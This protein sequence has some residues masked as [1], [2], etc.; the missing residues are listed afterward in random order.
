MNTLCID[1]GTTNIK[2]GFYQKNI[3][4]NFQSIPIKSH[5]TQDNH[6]IQKP[7]EIVNIINKSIRDL[8]SQ[9]LNI[10]MISFSVPMHTLIHHDEMILWS[11]LRANDW[12]IQFK[13]KEPKLAERFYQRT[14]TPIHPMSPFA[15]IGYLKQIKNQMFDFYY[16]LKE[17]LMHY[18]TEEF[19]IDYSTASATGLLNLNNLS[20][21][22]E[23]LNYLEIEE[24]QL[25]NLVDTDYMGSIL[26]QRSIELGLGEDVK[27]H[28]GATDGCLASLA[29]LENEG[30]NQVMTIG[31][32]G[33]A[34]KIVNQPMVSTETEDIQNFCYYIRQNQW[35]IGG[36][37]NNGGNI[38]DWLA[39][40]LFEDTTQFYGQL[41]TALKEIAPGSEGLKIYPYLYGERAPLWDANAQAS[42]NG[43]RALHSKQHFMKATVEG[44][45]F[46]L[47][48]ISTS[49]NFDGSISLNGGFFQIDGI[50]QLA[51]NILQQPVSYTKAS[52]PMD[53]L[54]CLINKKDV[55]K[56]EHLMVYPE[57]HEANLY[58]TAYIDWVK[59]LIRN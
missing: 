9:N 47:R 14:G 6:M 52:E 19:V 43:L 28:I 42:I 33:A 50:V 36:P 35:V 59:N 49:L 56:E 17:Y 8:I 13:E 11:D 30:A 26:Q 54:M 4:T 18:Y 23:V 55:S 22:E 37:T 48:S 46:N 1:I 51:A 3:R 7:K 16:G 31:T 45:L 34:R 41:P 12:I 39:K 29:A 24:S 38:L 15:K 2:T 21:D 44:I 5:Q 57:Q 32:S 40:L 27:I 58:Q 53:G 10:D 20:W 25:A